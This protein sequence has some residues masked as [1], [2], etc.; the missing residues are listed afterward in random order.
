MRP[1]CN[2][3]L[4]LHLVLQVRCA[5]TSEKTPPRP[6]NAFDC[7]VSFKWFLPFLL[8]T[9]SR[10]SSTLRARTG[11]KPWR[12]STASP[13]TRGAC[14]V[15][16]FISGGWKLLRS[17]IN[18]LSF[19]RFPPT[20]S[21]LHLFVPPSR[22]ETSKQRERTKASA[23]RAHSRE[24]LPTPPCPCPPPKPSTFATVTLRQ[25]PARMGILFQTLVHSHEHSL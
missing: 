8:F 1:C 17:S 25:Q 23:L 19:F 22:I 4:F 11:R 2:I 20:K 21:V 14:C 16:G 15:A 10:S 18:I 5:L 12:T 13:R 24:P 6:N 7:L 3:P 9:P